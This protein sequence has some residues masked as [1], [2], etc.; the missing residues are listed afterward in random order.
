MR[1]IALIF[2]LF[3]LGVSEGHATWTPQEVFDQLLA[4]GERKS[5]ESDDNDDLRDQK[6]PSEV[7]KKPSDVEKELE[8][9]RKRI[10]DLYKY[11]EPPLGPKK[12]PEGEKDTPEK[13]KNGDRK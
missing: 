13:P 4:A 8:E 5:E 9:E 10:F 2:P 3:L 12:S 1:K 6:G 11:L 7:P